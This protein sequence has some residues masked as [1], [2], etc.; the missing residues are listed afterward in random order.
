MWSGWTGKQAG[1]WG[2]GCQARSPGQ[3]P[4]V[5]SLPF[6]CMAAGEQER[7]TYVPVGGRRACL[8]HQ[9]L[10]LLSPGGKGVPRLG[11]M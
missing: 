10:N 5:L 8:S 3:H 11:P 7:V 2:V 1:A 6:P 9:A 4:V